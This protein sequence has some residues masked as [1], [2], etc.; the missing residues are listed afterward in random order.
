[1]NAFDRHGGRIG[2]G[3]A[4][5]RRWNTAP[6]ADRARYLRPQIENHCWY[7]IWKALFGHR[8]FPDAWYEDSPVALASRRYNIG[9]AEKILVAIEAAG[10][11]I[12]PADL[13]QPM[14]DV[15]HDAGWHGNIDGDHPCEERATQR[16]WDGLLAASPYAPTDGGS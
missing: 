8:L 3:A 10:L 6:E 15:G 2:A 14:L 12:V 13:L 9:Q 16:L 7:E 4:V 5:N 11:R 1:M